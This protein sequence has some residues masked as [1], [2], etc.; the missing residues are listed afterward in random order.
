MGLSP[1]SSSSLT[2]ASPMSEPSLSVFS[3]R[4]QRLLKD[5]LHCLVIRL[6]C[7][8][9]SVLPSSPSWDDSASSSSLARRT[10]QCTPDPLVGLGLLNCQNNCQIT[11]TPSLIG[12]FDTASRCF[13]IALTEF[14]PDAMQAPRESP[15]PFRQRCNS[16][17]RT[18]GCP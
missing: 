13:F 6:K 17:H 18:W 15:F 8:A 12:A 4:T 9:G 1:F 11:Q 7:L 2:S 5:A 16:V 10:R 3:S 14:P